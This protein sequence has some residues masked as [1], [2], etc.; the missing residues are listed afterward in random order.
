MGQGARVKPL[1]E[2]LKICGIA[3]GKGE[4]GGNRF[5]E[6]V[7]R[8]EGGGEK[9]GDGAESFE[10]EVEGVIG[11]ADRDGNGCLEELSV[12]VQCAIQVSVGEPYL[13]GVDGVGSTRVLGMVEVI[14]LVLIICFF[15]VG[16]PSSVVIPGILGTILLDSR[17]K[18]VLLDK[19]IILAGATR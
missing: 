11:T 1:S 16:S 14:S 12:V 5:T 18:R 9:G 19:E 4:S 3:L 17:S 15:F 13:V 6:A 8:I 10:V 2:V 7:C